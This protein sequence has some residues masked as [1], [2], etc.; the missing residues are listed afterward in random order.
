MAVCSLVR[1][2]AWTRRP[3][4]FTTNN[5]L[6]HH[7][8]RSDRSNRL[9]TCIRGL[10][11]SGSA[12]G[13]GESGE[14]ECLTESRLSTWRRQGEPVTSLTR[15]TYADA[16]RQGWNGGVYARIEKDHGG[17]H[18]A[19]SVRSMR[20]QH[21]RLHSARLCPLPLG[22]HNDA[23]RCVPRPVRPSPIR[24]PQAMSQRCWIGSAAG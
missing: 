4:V 5:N 22:Q 6:V 17:F 1:R 8:V 12:V 11:F 15:T 9:V 14:E 20:R 3:G 2:K 21:E 23:T 19:L 24:L 18:E 13:E 16:T 10:H 7:V